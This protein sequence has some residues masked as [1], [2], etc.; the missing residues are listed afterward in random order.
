MRANGDLGRR[1]S[2]HYAS[3]APHRAPDWL[4]ASALDTINITP[5]RRVLVR[6][7]WRFPIM[8]T[9]AKLGIA[10]V[11]AVVLVGG[12]VALLRSGATSNVGGAPSAA[13]S[14]VPSVAPSPRASPAATPISTT[15]WVPF[16]SERYGYQ[17]SYPPSHTGTTGSTVSAPTIVAQAQRD[18]VFGTD[19]F[20]ATSENAPTDRIILG[21]DGRE[22]A[23]AGFAATV[24]AG[25]SVDDI[26]NASFASLGLGPR[27]ESEPVSIDG[28][29]GRLDVCGLDISIAVAMVGDRAYVFNQ[30]RG[31]AEKDLMMAFLS[32]V[33][34]PTS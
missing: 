6:V 4:L 1:L 23:F 7:P 15:D 9:Y 26:I 21:P 33:R 17:I 12:V 16:T 24:P 22:I 28:H 30:G 32:T 14:A 11:F 8:N 34:F 13:L 10:A 18:F 27:C 31:A 29:P 3:E 5:Q 2:D 19:Q 25:T 20:E